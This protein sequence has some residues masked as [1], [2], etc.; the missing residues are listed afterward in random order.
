M[1]RTTRDPR[2]ARKGGNATDAFPRDVFTEAELVAVNRA[3]QWAEEGVAE[4]VRKATMQRVTQS[5]QWSVS[6]EL[7]PSVSMLRTAYP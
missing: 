3:A 2:A 5:A 7:P 6:G 1:K 4:Y